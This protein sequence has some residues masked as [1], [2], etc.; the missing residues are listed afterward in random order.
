M[1]TADSSEEVY[2]GDSL[3]MAQIQ[4]DKMLETIFRKQWEQHVL[5]GR[6][7]F[8]NSKLQAE[9]LENMRLTKEHDNT[10]GQPIEQEATT[11]QPETWS[12]KI[13]S[14]VKPTSLNLLGCA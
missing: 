9:T 4:V 10:V 7:K 13:D 1:E 11:T 3:P 5:K 8:V 2:R 6:F 14:R 12:R